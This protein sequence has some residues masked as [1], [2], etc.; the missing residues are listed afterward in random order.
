MTILKIPAY[1][2]LTHT[3]VNI[4]LTE[5][6][7]GGIIDIGS[8]NVAL[9][10]QRYVRNKNTLVDHSYIKAA[11]TAENLIN[12]PIIRRST[13]PFTIVLRLR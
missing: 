9:E 7:N 3:F 11:N 1:F 4:G 8:D 5:G 6:G 2:Y 13:K 12:S 10:Y